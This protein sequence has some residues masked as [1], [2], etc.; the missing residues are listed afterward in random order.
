[1]AKAKNKVE[2]SEILEENIEGLNEQ[3]ANVESKSADKAKPKKASKKKSDDIEEVT[4]EQ[5]TE[6]PTEVKEIKPKAKSNKT[7]KVKKFR[8]KMYKDTKKDLRSKE[9]YSVEE[10][11][12]LLKKLPTRKFNES[13]ETHI[14]LGI[15]T[16]N[17][18][19]RVRFTTS[20]PFGIGKSV[21]ILVIT[22]KDI[23][24]DNK[25]VVVKDKDA[26]N[27]IFSN[28][29]VPGKDFDVV[30]TN[31]SMMKDLGKIAK[32][33][34]PKGM[35][36]SPKNNT[37]TENISKAIEQFAKGQVEIKTQSGHGVIHQIVG[38]KNFESN[39]IVDNINTLLEELNKHAPAKLKKKFVQSV[40]LCTTM[41]PSVKV[42]V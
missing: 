5:S 3:D 20:L 29:L 11:V 14:N 36:P 8:G 13:I 26:I 25:D 16:K 30:I 17:S 40:Y 42:S 4:E 9:F 21:K 1:M 39:Q 23:K 32:I 37:I 24:I 15:D 27:E 22:D 38:T 19:H 7:S 34:G 12:N 31:P 41:S 2:Q 10:A 33:L 6:E 28:K 18:D 35:M